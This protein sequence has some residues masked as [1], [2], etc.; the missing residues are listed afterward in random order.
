MTQ[1]TRYPAI[2]DI[3]LAVLIR[4]EEGAQITPELVARALAA[5]LNHPATP[6]SF[7]IVR[8][9]L[10]QAHLLD[11]EGRLTTLADRFAGFWRKFLAQR[12][13]D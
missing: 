1:R 13:R 8:A 7:E 2:L 5:T 11:D 4:A 6:E 3:S 10:D 9:D 12:A